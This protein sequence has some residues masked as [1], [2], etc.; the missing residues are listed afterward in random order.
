MSVGEFPEWILNGFKNGL[1]QW[2]L[3]S[4]HPPVL[5]ELPVE[6]QGG[7]GADLALALHRKF[8][9]DQGLAGDGRV[10]E[11]EDFLWERGRGI[12][13]PVSGVRAG[14]VKIRFCGT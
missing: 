10:S 14:R 4:Q 6:H 13:T 5:G 8:L 3:Q 1:G 9:M 2:Q 7:K 11:L 12:H